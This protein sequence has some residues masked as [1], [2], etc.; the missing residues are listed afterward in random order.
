[1]RRGETRWAQ[2]PPCG[3]LLPCVVAV[4]SLSGCTIND[5]NHNA[6]IRYSMAMGHAQRVLK[7]AGSSL[8]ILKDYN[9]LTFRR[10]HFDHDTRVV[11]VFELYDFVKNSPGVGPEAFVIAYDKVTRKTY[12]R[13]DLRTNENLETLPTESPP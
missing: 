11:H 8:E 6:K 1:M 9:T 2:R 7:E 4:L 12:L 3:G 5:P 10:M 13:A